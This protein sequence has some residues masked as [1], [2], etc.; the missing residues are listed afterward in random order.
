M[1]GGHFDYIQF[2][3]DDSANKI[4]W[5]LKNY[6]YPPEVIEKIKEAQVTLR[7]AATMLNRVDWLV[8][9]DDGNETFLK[10]WDEDLSKL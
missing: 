5:L 6:D 2:Q 8:S 1:S 10:R 9:G 4:D 3:I 7:K